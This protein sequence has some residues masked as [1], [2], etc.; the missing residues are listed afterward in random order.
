MAGLLNGSETQV[1][2]GY[3]RATHSVTVSTSTP[4]QMTG[5]EL[6]GAATGGNASA[7]LSNNSIYVNGQKLDLQ[8]YKINGSNYFKLRDLAKAIDF[9]VGYENGNITV[10]G[11]EGYTE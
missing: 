8:V 11:S 2:V 10:S 9:Y 3:D 7:A 4:Y 6:K 5:T 1:G